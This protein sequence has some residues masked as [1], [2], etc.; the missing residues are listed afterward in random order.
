MYSIGEFSRISGLGVKTLRFYHERG[1]LVPAA[2]DEQTGYRYY[3]TSN[4]ET[5]RII[6]ALRDFEFSLDD[7]AVM[8]S[9]CGDDQ[10]LV[11]FLERH[12][13]ALRDRLRYYQNVI[14]TIDDLLARERNAW[15]VP[16]MGHAFEI[17]EREIESLVVAGLRMKGKYSDCGSGF[18]VVA[19]EIGRHIAG[20]PMCLFYD[21]EYQEEDADFEACF[22]IRKIV[23]TANA[24]VR[25]LPRARCVTLLHRGPYNTLGQSYKRVLDY[26]KTKG[27]AIDLP[28]REVYIKGP[29]MI[30]KGNPSRYLTEIQLP[31]RS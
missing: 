16:T 14:Q 25:E 24:A 3:N 11:G 4:I 6:R 23:K 21:G 18:S 31:V 29:G 27:Y 17:E 1:L 2:V 13:H 10:D 15:E 19:K 12:K 22:P 30:F 9:E 7:I 20:K 8:L 26:T 5:A 28:T